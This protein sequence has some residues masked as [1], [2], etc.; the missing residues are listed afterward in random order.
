M[1]PIIGRCDYRLR[2]CSRLRFH[3]FRNVITEVDNSLRVTR[4]TTPVHLRMSFVAGRIV[5]HIRDGVIQSSVTVYTKNHGTLL[6]ICGS[7]ALRVCVLVQTVQ[8]Q[9]SILCVRLKTRWLL[10]Y[11]ESWYVF[12]QLHVRINVHL[13][14]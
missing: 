11:R 10:P 13:N 3:E 1:L 7:D 8:R 4:M 12:L 5:L 2:C 6:Y 14:I 9:P